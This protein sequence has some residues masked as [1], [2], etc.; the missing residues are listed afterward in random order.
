MR[1]SVILAM[2]VIYVMSIVVITFFG[3]SIS[4]DQF[5]VYMTNIEITNYTGV[6]NNGTKYLII[7]FDNKE[8][9]SSVF[10]DYDTAPD[11]ATY[12]G[13]VTFSISGNTSTNEDG[14]VETYAEVSK[15]GE[16]LFYK[17]QSAIVTISTADGSRLS[18]KILIICQ[19][20]G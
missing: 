12:P 17:P 6:T 15:N 13:K 11:A 7:E 1:K 2:A 16:V 9:Y 20:V 19:S 3:M 14:S 10:I 18:D 8:G 5:Q 4:V